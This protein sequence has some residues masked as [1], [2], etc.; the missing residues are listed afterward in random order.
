MNDNVNMFYDNIVFQFLLLNFHHMLNHDK[1]DM[2]HENM[3]NV[4]RRIISF[5]KNHEHQINLQMLLIL[6]LYLK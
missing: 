6:I 4:I 1:L 5:I 2:V 3:T